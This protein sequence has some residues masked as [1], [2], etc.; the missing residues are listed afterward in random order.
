MEKGIANPSPRPSSLLFYILHS[1][2]SIPSR[3]PDAARAEQAGW[4]QDEDEE[5][6]DEGDRVAIVGG[7]GQGDA[8]DLGEAEEVAADDRARDRAHPAENDHGQALQLDRAAHRRV[9]A[10]D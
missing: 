2:F 6:E 3:F 4:P 5:E 10:A 7:I 1:S 9:E 8:E